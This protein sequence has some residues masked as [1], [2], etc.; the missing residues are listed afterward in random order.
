LTCIHLKTGPGEREVNFAV[1]ATG[2]LV[3]RP[4]RHGLPEIDNAALPRPPPIIPSIAALLSDAAHRTDPFRVPDVDFDAL[5]NLFEP[6]NTDTFNM[7]GI[8]IDAA[9]PDIG[10][11]SGGNAWDND[12]FDISWDPERTFRNQSPDLLSPLH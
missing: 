9:M 8:S 6:F 2:R 11:M 7:P 10:G 1:N 4:P 5:S 3:H 12:A